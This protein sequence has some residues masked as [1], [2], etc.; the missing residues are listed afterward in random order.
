MS[1]TASQRYP[2]SARR[3]SS[4][5][6]TFA[7]RPLGSPGGIGRAVPKPLPTPTITP[8]IP[9]PLAAGRLIPLL[10]L[11]LS[12]WELWKLYNEWINWN[13]SGLTLNGWSRTDNGCGRSDF[14]WNPG[15][16]ATCATYTSAPTGIPNV[17]CAQAK[18]GGFIGT[19]DMTGQNTAT[20][21]QCFGT[22]PVFNT[23]VTYGPAAR[24]NRDVAGLGDNVPAAPRR[25]IPRPELDP[26]ADPHF[27]PRFIPQADP[28]SAPPPGE[29]FAPSPGYSP[30]PYEY[31]PYLPSVSPGGEPVR[32][33]VP[34]SR[35]R[36]QRNPFRGPIVKPIPTRTR[37]NRTPSPWVRPRGP[38]DVPAPNPS[39][40]Q[41][42]PRPTPRP[43]PRTDPD[44][45][46]QVHPEPQTSTG[47]EPDGNGPPRTVNIPASRITWPTRGPTRYEPRTFHRARPPGK[48]TK[49][50]KGPVRYPFKFVNPWTEACEAIDSVYKALPKKVRDLYGHKSPHCTKFDEDGS[51]LVNT[52][53]QASR[54]NKDRK[55]AAKGKRPVDPAKREAAARR[56]ERRREEFRRKLPEWLKPKDPCKPELTCQAKAGIIY[57][58]INK[59]NPDVALR[60]LAKDQ[61][62]DLAIGVLSKGGIPLNEALGRPVGV[63]AGPAI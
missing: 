22:H 34:P 61:L 5:P 28:W 59:L 3:G 63:G 16:D 53:T 46:E 40:P 12:L 51:R 9:L 45:G 23:R 47:G 26:D 54:A 38:W 30:V 56:H 35:P 37:P 7:R 14:S 21:Y 36:P 29:M 62:V 20:S 25:A 48:F 60:N 58:E 11:A 1:Q 39:E 10:G 32:G 33:P 50:K 2:G 4:G 44:P 8:R 52:K 6:G 18:A 27:I 42:L 43:R 19:N 17:T 31:V 15:L 13:N 41:E 49:E 55:R 57:R 24:W